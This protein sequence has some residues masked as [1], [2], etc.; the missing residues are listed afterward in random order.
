[1][2]ERVRKHTTTD[3]NE[4]IDEKTKE[5]ITRYLLQGKTAISKRIKELEKEW[6]IERALEVN[7]PI[8]ALIGLSLTVFVS[9]WWAIFPTLVLQFFLQHAIQGWCPPLP[10]F[11]M[12]G[13]RTKKEIEKERY[14]L[15]LLRGDFDFLASKEPPTATEVYKAISQS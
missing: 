7:M 3:V 13:F 14:A 6:D 10:V 11:R 5:N 1:M 15:K 12:L 9:P 8:V 2:E 4:K